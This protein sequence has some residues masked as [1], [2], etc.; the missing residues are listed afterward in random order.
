MK[1][2]YGYD[3]LIEWWNSIITNFDSLSIIARHLFLICPNSANCERGFSNFDWLT[4]KRCFQLGI[5]KL[6][7]MSKMISYWKSNVK[8]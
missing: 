7:I 6:E 1:F 4:N 8:L 5:E 3:E 2:G